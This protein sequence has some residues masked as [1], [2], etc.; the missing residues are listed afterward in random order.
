MDRPLDEAASAPLTT[1]PSAEYGLAFEQL[2]LPPP[3]VLEKTPSTNATLKEMAKTAAEW[4]TVIAEE[5]T[6]GRG[7]LGRR[8]ESRRGESLTMSTLVKPKL[9]VRDLPLVMLAAGVAV[10]EVLGDSFR[11]KWPNDVLGPD[12]AKVCGMLA[13]VELSSGG[14]IEH[15]VL[16]IGINVHGV[17]KGEFVAGAVNATREDV[18]LFS[19]AAGI[20]ASLRSWIR[21]LETDHARV[22]ARWRAVDGTRGREVRVSD[23]KGIAS[24]IRDDGALLVRNVAGELCPILA[25]DVEMV[26]VHQTSAGD[27]RGGM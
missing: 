18:E 19:M 24:G 25:G 7:R 15:V 13:E 9:P 21:V 22:L 2:E 4:S 27:G 8:W 6:A 5:Q 3:L 12:G 11:L 20:V 16:G 23:I 10:Q 26:Q 17:P 1:V 14:A